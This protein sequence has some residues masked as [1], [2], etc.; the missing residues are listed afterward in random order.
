MRQNLWVNLWWFGYFISSGRCGSKGVD[1]RRVLLEE[2][3]QCPG[4]ICLKGLGLRK[5]KEVSSRQ[6]VVRIG[7]SWMIKLGRKNEECGSGNVQQW[8]IRASQRSKWYYKQPAEE[9]LWMYLSILNKILLSGQCSECLQRLCHSF[10]V[11]LVGKLKCICCNSVCFHD[12]FRT[13]ASQWHLKL[14][15]PIG[16]SLINFILNNSC[17]SV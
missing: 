4:R 11:S 15:V 16:F 7:M 10:K 13:H 1:R 6:R 9:L 2:P 12:R 5:R 14:I 8:R 17:V 3:K